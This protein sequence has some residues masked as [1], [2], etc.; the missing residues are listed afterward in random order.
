VHGDGKKIWIGLSH[1]KS[2]MKGNFISGNGFMTKALPVL[3]ILAA[4][5]FYFGV[6]LPKIFGDNLVLQVKKPIPNG[7]CRQHGK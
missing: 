3:S 4:S 2:G 1:F 7:Y 5:Y 6:K